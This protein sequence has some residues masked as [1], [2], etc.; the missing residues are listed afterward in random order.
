M[1]QLVGNNNFNKKYKKLIKV[2]PNLQDIILKFLKVLAR[3]P[4]FPSIRTHKV[5]SK[6]FG[7]GYS[8][9]VTG[10]IRVIWVYGKQNQVL[11]LELLDIGGHSGSNKVY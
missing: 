1:Y 4:F 11:V 2:N 10:D 6:N 8:S 3:D 9:R 5:I 7:E